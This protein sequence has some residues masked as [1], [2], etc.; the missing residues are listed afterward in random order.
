MA[1][2]A[3]SSCARA[4]PSPRRKPSPTV[5]LR[6]WGKSMHARNAVDQGLFGTRCDADSLAKPPHGQIYFFAF[7]FRVARPVAG[8]VVLRL[9]R[10]LAP[11]A[12][13]E[14]DERLPRAA[15]LDL[16]PLSFAFD[17]VGVRAGAAARFRFDCAPSPTITPATPPS[18]APIGPAIAAP[19][20]APVS[21]PI[22]CLGTP[23]VRVSF[24]LVLSVFLVIV[25]RATVSPLA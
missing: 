23:S 9:V 17:R 15:C 7:F 25:C 6:G 20:A 22:A 11:A 1:I 19:T 24:A 21:P 8:L 10:A 18:T 16:W 5:N 14:R 13:L 12:L 4:K 2:T 3:R